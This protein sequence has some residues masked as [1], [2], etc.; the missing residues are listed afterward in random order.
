MLTSLSGAEIATA[1][2]SALISAIA[3]LT[4]YSY[5]AGAR[6]G[7]DVWGRIGSAVAGAL[8]GSIVALLKVALH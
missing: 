4:V 1:A 8:L 7:L 2:W 6:G 5:L 3:L